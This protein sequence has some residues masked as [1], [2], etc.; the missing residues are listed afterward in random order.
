MSDTLITNARVLTLR[1]DSLGDTGVL[2]SAD[3]LVRGG[4][5]VSVG[6]G[7][8]DQGV[9]QFDAS[10][11]VLMPAFV[12]CHTHACWAGCRLAEW[13]QK[14]KGVSYLEL[15]AAGGGIMSTVRSVRDASRDELRDGLLGRLSKMQRTGTLTAEVKSGY[16]LSTKDEIKM[17][18]AISEAGRSWAGTVVPTACIGHAKDPDVDDFVTRTIEETLPEV[19]RCFP[20]ITIDAYC[21]EGSWSL[22]ETLRLF[23]AAQ[24]AGH[25][26]RVHADQFNDLGMIP[27][28]IKRGFLS[29]D[30]LEATSPEHLKQLAQSDCFGVMLPVCGM[31]LDNRFGD[32]RSFVDAGGKLAIASNYNPGSAPCHSMP[33]VIAAAVRHLGLLPAEAIAASTR[34]PARLLGLTDRGT[35]ET[36]QR[37]D[38]ILLDMTD[39]RELAFEFGANPV[40]AV[41]AAG[42]KIV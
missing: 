2:D 18:E 11:R 28:A 29:V 4:K 3:V 1:G 12:D 39:E 32:G 26:I 21:E 27:E 17:L 41:W 20:G 13:E 42:R 15:L 38:L 23:E 8:Q 36:G 24:E 33:T 35:I 14:L 31:H 16:G 10:G 7:L 19:T 9:Q 37:A 5:I 22:D 34:S 40:S 30:H 25:P 6:D